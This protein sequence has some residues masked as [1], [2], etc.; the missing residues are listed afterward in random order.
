MHNNPQLEAPAMPMLKAVHRAANT[1]TCNWQSDDFPDLRKRH[2]SFS[3]MLGESHLPWTLGRRLEDDFRA[4]VN[5]R[6]FG[7]YRLAQCHCS[8]LDGF[9]SISELASTDA[10]YLTLL[11]L[12]EG[13]ER[14]QAEGREIILNAGDL[15][16]WD[17]TQKMRFWV[18]EHVVKVSLLIP[19]QT[20][21]S[22]LPQVHDYVGAVIRHD[23]SMSAIL[24]AHM[25][26]LGSQ[27]N[28]LDDVQLGS[29]MD[30]T[31]GLLTTTLKSEY[32]V[33]R[34]IQQAMLGRIQEY[35]VARL[36]DSD[37]S[38]AGIAATFGISIRHLYALFERQGTSVAAW[39]RAR[40]MERAR[41]DL[42][43]ASL[44]GKT[45]TEIA[46]DWGYSD[47]SHFSKAFKQTY[48]QAPRDFMRQCR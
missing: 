5:F 43:T 10:A 19:E 41:H 35:V 17:S 8:G 6:S 32:G 46:L 14:L 38:P 24:G 15:I 34:S 27:I 47:L 11:Y 30:I 21:L 23:T 40:R 22:H 48:G 26:A 13:R 42:E 18:P 7:A 37:L 2:E 36:D 4:A 33:D 20:F 3:H 45:V 29:I 28:T 9:R 1:S 31:L 39:I 25:R 16:L 44:S 12:Q